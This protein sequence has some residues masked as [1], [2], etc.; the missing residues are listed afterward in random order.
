MGGGEREG[1]G[2]R[3]EGGGERERGEG[4]GERVQGGKALSRE[5]CERDTREIRD[6]RGTRNRYERAI[7]EGYRSDTRG[8]WVVR[9][10]E[11]G[12]ERGATLDK[13][14]SL[15]ALC[16]FAATNGSNPLLF[17]NCTNALLSSCAFQNVPILTSK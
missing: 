8:R 6:A 12:R 3:G 16:Q 13:V 4:G 7:R 14:T 10:E 11:S 1:R 5:G 17:A 9:R 2:R 15:L